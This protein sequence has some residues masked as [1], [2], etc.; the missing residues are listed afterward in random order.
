MTLDNLGNIGELIG[1][2]GVIV[3]LVYL[4]MQIRQNTG[5]FRVRIRT[6]SPQ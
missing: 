6:K 2:I 4:A 3:T 5:A 1:A